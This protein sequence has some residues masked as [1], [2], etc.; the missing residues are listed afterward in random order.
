MALFKF[1]KAILAGETIQVFNHGKMVRDFTY[2]DDIVEGVI[3][4][5]D[6]PA[7]PAANWSGAHPTP[8]S[9]SAPYR[10]FNIGNNEPVEL[11]RYIQAIE[12]ATGKTA[13][14]QMLPIQPGDVHATSADVTRLDALTGFKPQ[15][16][17]EDGV[18]KFVAWYRGYYQL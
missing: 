13:K 14:M 8:D 1:T 5:I 11:M 2:I 17:V 9:S 6:H 15:T 3:R 18:A 7:T 12:T 4:V 10:I 16:K